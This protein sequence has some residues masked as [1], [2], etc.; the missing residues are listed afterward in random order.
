MF[1]GL[2]ERNDILS[3]ARSF[4][5][6]AALSCWIPLWLILVLA[7]GLRLYRLEAKGLWVDEIFTVVFASA[8]NDL[9]T[10]V[11]RALDTPLP[12]PPLWFLITHAFA[13]TFGDSEFAIRLPSVLAGVL[14]VVAIYKVGKLLFNRQVGLV[15]AFFLATSPFHVLVAREGRFYAAVAFFSLVTLYCLIRGMQTRRKRWWLGFVLASLLNIYIHLTTLLV[16]V[17]ELLYASAV[18][19]LQFRSARRAGHRWQLGQTFARSLLVSA[20]AIAI[21][22]LPMLPYLVAGAMHTERGLGVSG[23]VFV[24]SGGDLLSILESFS[25]GSGSYLLLYAG[26]AALALITIFRSEKRKALLWILWFAVPLM[27]IFLLRSRHW[28]SVKYVVAMLPMFLILTAAGVIEIVTRA[29]AVWHHVWSR[30][31]RW[32][33]H[34]GASLSFSSL[35]SPSL[36][37]AL[38]TTIL[39]YGIVNASSSRM[40]RLYDDNGGY[41]REVGQVLNNNVQ[42]GDIVVTPPLILLTMRPQE[43]ISYYG[44]ESVMEVSDGRILDKLLTKYSRVWVIRPGGWEEPLP[45]LRRM[46]S[47]LPPHVELSLNGNFRILYMGERQSRLS[48]LTEAMRFRGLP[49]SAQASISRAYRSLGKLDAAMLANERAVSS[50]PQVAAWHYARAL[51]YERQGNLDAAR[52]AFETASSLDPRNPDLLFALGRSY[53]RL[54]MAEQAVEHYEEAMRLHRRKSNGDG[55]AFAYAV[56][57]RLANLTNGSGYN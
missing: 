16:L 3:P 25:A 48:L 50:E 38:G 22:Y 32:F 51:I 20:G 42:P 44:P 41:W 30:A 37:L 24:L 52:V 39:A 4:S 17:T 26:P 23:E 7:L 49:A 43:L 27:L 11:S 2:L 47:N 9:G 5:R 57:R 19:T 10:I 28:F 21:C 40:P 54:D 33:P 45:R 15:A 55:D 34:A 14:G 46:W 13:R 12:S 29:P 31:S 36:V 8:A 53:E 18:L 56:N 35:R 6:R 1:T